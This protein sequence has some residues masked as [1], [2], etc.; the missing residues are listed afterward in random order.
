VRLSI[1]QPGEFASGLRLWFEDN[2]IRSVDI[3]VQGTAVGEIAA[4]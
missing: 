1:K 4:P 3:S 2:G